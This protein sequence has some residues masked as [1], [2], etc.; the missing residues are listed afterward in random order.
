MVAGLQLLLVD[1]IY[2]SRY[3]RHRRPARKD[4]IPEE[5]ISL[6]TALVGVPS[7]NG[8]EDLP[9]IG[10]LR[11]QLGVVLSLIRLQLLAERFQRGIHLNT[12]FC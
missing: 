4:H 3:L 7:E 5:S 2:S 12:R 8:A 10:E 9:E 11:G 1:N 6:P